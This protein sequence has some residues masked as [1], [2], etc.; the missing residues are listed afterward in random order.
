M[1]QPLHPQRPSADITRYKILRAAKILFAEKG[2]SA[3]SISMIA[4]T[5][6]INQSLIYHHFG[7]KQKLW[8][9]VKSDL[10]QQQLDLN[11]TDKVKFKTCASLEELVRLIFNARYTLYDAHPEILRMLNWQRVESHEDKVYP[12][13][14]ELYKFLLGRINYFQS[15][16][17]INPKINPDVAVILILTASASWFLDEYPPMLIATVEQLEDIKKQYKEFAIKSVVAALK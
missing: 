6:K 17:M 11:E 2:F 12:I 7:D 9:Q 14:E 4:K 5:A 10:L 3:T 13:R 1:E 8:Q 16:A 15:E